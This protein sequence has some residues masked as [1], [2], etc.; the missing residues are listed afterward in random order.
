MSEFR[1]ESGM[2]SFDL[3]I[4]HLTPPQILITLS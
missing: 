3:K 4:Y 1:K 2:L